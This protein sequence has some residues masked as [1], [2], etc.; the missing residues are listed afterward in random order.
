VDEALRY[1]YAVTIFM[2]RL[3]KQASMRRD[4]SMLQPEQYRS[5]ALQCTQEELAAPLA[6]TVFDPPS[7]SVTAE[8][9]IAAIEQYRPPPTR[10]RPPR[11]SPVLDT[12]D[13]VE[14]ALR[15][16]REARAVVTAQVE[17]LLNGGSAADVTI[18]IRDASWRNVARTTTD[19]ITASSDPEIPVTVSLSTHLIIRPTGPVSHITPMTLRRGSLPG[20]GISASA[21]ND[22][23]GAPDD[24]P[25]PE[26]PKEGNHE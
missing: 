6:R 20:Q 9:I 1:D 23:D 13:P 8:E 18:Q 15:R 16:E 24:I 11:P 19:V 25:E 17:L 14:D 4:F 22:S 3:Y 10:R 2:E 7:I 26:D 5:A 12:R 21:P